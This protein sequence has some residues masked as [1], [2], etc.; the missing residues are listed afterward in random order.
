MK[1]TNFLDHPRVLKSSKT[2]VFAERERE[3]MVDYSR[4][5]VKCAHSESPPPHPRTPEAS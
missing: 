3:S 2:R 4:W 5:L 1:Q